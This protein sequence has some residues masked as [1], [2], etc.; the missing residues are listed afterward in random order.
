MF[1]MREQN[2][3]S[4]PTSHAQVPSMQMESFIQ[5]S[6]QGSLQDDKQKMIRSNIGAKYLIGKPELC[7][8]QSIAA[9]NYVKIN[10]LLAFSDSP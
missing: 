10:A 2:S 9:R 1:D 7:I 6:P 3:P 4:Y 8:R 5:E